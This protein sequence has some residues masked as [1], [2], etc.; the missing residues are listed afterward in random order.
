MKRVVGITKQQSHSHKSGKQNY[1]NSTSEN[2]RNF[3]WQLPGITGAEAHAKE[4]GAA[5]KNEGVITTTIK[6][7]GVYNK[8]SQPP[9]YSLIDLAQLACV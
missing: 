5:P 4:G 3:A 1:Y 8:P 7:K 9:H 2:I 6:K